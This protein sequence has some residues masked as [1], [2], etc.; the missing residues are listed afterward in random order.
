MLM[1]S[2]CMDTG[3]E[4]NSVWKCSF[5]SKFFFRNNLLLEHIDDF[6]LFCAAI[7]R[8]LAMFLVSDYD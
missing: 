5:F 2:E 1:S 4:C 6:M 7:E 8:F 3:Q